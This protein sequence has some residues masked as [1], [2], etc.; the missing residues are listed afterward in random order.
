MKS[1]EQRPPGPRRPGG[2]VRAIV[3][4]LLLSLAWLGLYGLTRAHWIGEQGLWLLLFL[5]VP[6][7]VFA[8]VPVRPPVRREPE[9][10]HRRQWK[11]HEIAP[12][13]DIAALWPA[14]HPL[15]REGERGGARSAP[16]TG[17]D[18]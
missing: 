12:P 1:F 2:S 18:T 5:V 9:R 15:D 13:I 4:T 11:G 3:A 17:D 8:L 6:I 14:A 7:A 10:K 16:Q